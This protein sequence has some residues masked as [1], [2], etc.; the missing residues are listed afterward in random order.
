VRIY[1]GG[2]GSVRDEA[3]LW[4]E[5]LSPGMRIVYWP[6]ALASPAHASARTWL[7]DSLAGWG[8][9]RV[10]MWSSLSGRTAAELAAA[11]LLFVGG[12]N[13]FALLDE[14]VRNDFLPAVRDYLGAGGALYGGSAGAILAGADIS[15]AAS[16]DA[17][18]VGLTR[19]DALDLLGG[20]MVRPHYEPGQ[21]AELVTWA[22]THRRTVLAIPE[23]S[24]VA[25]VDGVARTAGPE[26][27]HLIGPDRREQRTA[28]DSWLLPA[29]PNDPGQPGR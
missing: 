18:E 7:L 19:T 2:G 23:R 3:A 4:D 25:V 22:A 21:E 6:F 15:I 26:A 17:N 28:G 8:D 12:G 11:D 16:V 10:S 24:G 9:F 14:V 5:F 27:V 13:T 29:D 1:L 20:L